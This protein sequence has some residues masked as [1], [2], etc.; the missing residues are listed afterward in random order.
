MK[1]FCQ[2]QKCRQLKC[3]ICKHHHVKTHTI[4]L[5][6]NN[7][8]FRVALPPRF[9]SFFLTFCTI[10]L[11]FHISSDTDVLPTMADTSTSDTETLDSPDVSRRAGTI[12]VVLHRW[13]LSRKKVCFHFFFNEKVKKIAKKLQKIFEKSSKIRK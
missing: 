1:N 2:I 5:R 6:I 4:L 7:C 3:P 8:H 13:V 9:P 12:H 10:F 11:Y